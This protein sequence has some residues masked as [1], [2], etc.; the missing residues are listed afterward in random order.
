[1]RFIHILT[2]PKDNNRAVRY[3][4]ILVLKLSRQMVHKWHLS[5]K[6][7]ITRAKAR[8]RASSDY[9]EIDK[10][11]MYFVRSYI[12]HVW[13]QSE[14]NILYIH[15]RKKVFNHSVLL[16][17]KWLTNSIELLFHSLW[18][19]FNCDG[20]ANLFTFNHP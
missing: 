11:N 18:Q 16:H 6:K 2:S 7:N 20:I 8:A 1:M 5:V 4:S 12:F 19:H 13:N 10:F 15:K 14:Q 3:D 17:P 9:I